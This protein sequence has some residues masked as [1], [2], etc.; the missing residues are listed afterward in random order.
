MA[1]ESEADIAIQT[2]ILI[3]Y[4]K[5]NKDKCQKSGTGTDTVVFISQ[6]ITNVTGRIN[7][8]KNAHWN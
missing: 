2:L 6:Q 1:T 5:N 4:C 3:R 7:N 8:K